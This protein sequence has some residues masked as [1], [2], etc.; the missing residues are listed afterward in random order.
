MEKIY[1]NNL[2]GQRGI[3]LIALV[4]TIVVLLILAGVT[5]ATLTGE[6]GIL[7]QAGKAKEETEI[8]EEK[9][10]IQLAVISAKM[11]DNGKLEESFLNA[12]L[13]TNIGDENYI[14]TYYEE[15]NLYTVTIKA[16]GRTY[17]IDSDENATYL[18][19]QK[20]LLNSIAIEAQNGKNLE[21]KLIQ[22]EKITITSGLPISNANMQVLY[23]WSTDDINKP[24]IQTF[25]NAEFTGTMMLKK[26]EIESNVTEENNYYLYITVITDET[27]IEEKFG[28]YA[29]KDHTMLK[30]ASQQERS[31]S[32]SGFLGLDVPRGMI[33]EINIMD[34]KQGNLVDNITY[35]NITADSDKTGKENYIA[36]YD[37]D[38]SG[39][40][41]VNI[42]G[43]GG[44]VANV[45][46]QFLFA[47][48]GSGV[49]N[50]EVTINGLE[51]LDTGIT[52]SMINMFMHSP[53]KKLDLS[54]WDVS[55]VSNMGQQFA[56]YGMFLGCSKL[57]TINLSG[58]KTSKLKYMGSMFTN[59]SKLT[60]IDLSSF[61]TS[62]VTDM[63]ELF[64]GCKSLTNINLS[65]WDIS[66]V[67]NI[68]RMLSG[69]STSVLITT[70]ENV[71][72][73]L[74]TNFPAYT[75]IKIVN[76]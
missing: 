49:K 40:Y 73:W 18:G 3:T 43:D 21:P 34:S 65:G 22:K 13:R 44:I 30:A 46:S 54:S 35:F 50:N 33:K 72:T 28:P 5:I 23:A 63:G 32:S 66:K 36:W 61:D 53:V 74:N 10:K 20:E 19:L 12:E 29:V 70:N 52:T 11:S 39:Y 38:D 8:G 9:E 45:N 69:V 7:N 41:T 67:S 15:G 2:R 56:W 24:D 14:L 27:I 48:I 37:K 57:E 55:N 25:K 4:I 76:E 16:S 6:N 71:A 62:K 75:N 47:N 60:S 26:M 68:W 1:E 51:N 31:D 42:A 58:W 64:N 59:C 17:L